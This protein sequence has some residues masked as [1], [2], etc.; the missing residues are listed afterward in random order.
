MGRSE[1]VQ[2]FRVGLDQDEPF[3]LDSWI[4]AAVEGLTRRMAQ[5]LIEREWI[6]VNR[7]PARKG[8]RLVEGDTIEVWRGGFEAEWTAAPAPEI[9]LAV[10]H[11]DPHLIA[12]DK[13]SGVPTIPLSPDERGTLAGAVAAHFPECV[14]LGRS[15][16]DS[17]LIQRLDRETSGLVLA[18]RTP[19]AFAALLELQQRNAIEKTYQ[20]LVRGRSADLPSSVDLALGPAGPGGRAVRPDP[21]GA[22]ATTVLSSCEQLGD[23]LLVTATIHRGFRHQIRAHL[24]HVGLPI[25]GDELYGGPSAPGIDRLFLHAGEVALPHPMSGELLECR[26]PLPRDLA[27]FVRPHR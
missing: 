17:G 9:D 5:Q 24:A 15:P 19:A 18:A 11:E 6:T 1:P 3:R 4:A 8:Q 23:W 12:L 10:V 16:G 22:A 27:H 14:P 26:S 21:E 20:A 25:A 7:R 2:Q 13:P